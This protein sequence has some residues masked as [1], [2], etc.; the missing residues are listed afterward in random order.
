M[1]EGEP[2]D[3]ENS[4]RNKNLGPLDHLQ[5][6]LKIGHTSDSALIQNFVLE[7][8]LQKELREFIKQTNN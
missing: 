5:H 4:S 3:A 1:S 8:N 2:V 6:L 7:H